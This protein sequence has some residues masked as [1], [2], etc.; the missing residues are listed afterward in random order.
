MTAVDTTEMRFH[1]AA[2]RADVDGGRCRNVG[3]VHHACSG[4]ISHSTSPP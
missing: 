2:E 1:G 4:S 3:V